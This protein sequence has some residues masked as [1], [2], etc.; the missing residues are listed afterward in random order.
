MDRGIA[1]R[2]GNAW[3]GIGMAESVACKPGRVRG[4]AGMVS[5]R[6]PKVPGDEISSLLEE[7]SI[8]GMTWN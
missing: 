4:S 2:R 7:S 1:V 5:S 8:S 6:R 3:R